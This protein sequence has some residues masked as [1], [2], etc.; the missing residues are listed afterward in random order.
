[1]QRGSPLRENPKFNGI[2]GNFVP[3]KS[4][5]KETYHNK[6]VCQ[7]VESSGIRGEIMVRDFSHSD[8]D[9]NPPRT[10]AGYRVYDLR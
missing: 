5:E 8:T 3:S 4:P 10:V 2:W 9:R 6:E 1:M 7:P